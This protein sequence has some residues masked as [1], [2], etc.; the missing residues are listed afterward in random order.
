MATYA[1]PA[2]SSVRRAFIAAALASAVLVAAPALAQTPRKIARVGVLFMIPQS[3]LKIGLDVV[4]N[5]YWVVPAIGCAHELN[6]PEF[7]RDNV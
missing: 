1:S 5:G 7:P 4:D 3:L 6:A 2:G